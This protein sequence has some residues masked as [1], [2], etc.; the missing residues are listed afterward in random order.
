MT[1]A[2]VLLV[3]GYAL[4]FWS[5]RKL[6]RAKAAAERDR[7][8]ADRQAALEAKYMVPLMT[9]AQIAEMNAERWSGD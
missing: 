5:I 7:L 1:L 6:R 3:V 4:F 9:E 2:A 8:N